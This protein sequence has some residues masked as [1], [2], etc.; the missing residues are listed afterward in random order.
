MTIYFHEELQSKGLTVVGTWDSNEGPNFFRMRSDSQSLIQ[1][2]LY[3]KT[4][5]VSTILVNF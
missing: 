2:S 4:L 3:N 1:E 5:I